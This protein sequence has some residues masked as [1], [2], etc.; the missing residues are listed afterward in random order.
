MK[1][2]LVLVISVFLFP[3]FSQPILAHAG[4]IPFLKINSKYAPANPNYYAAPDLKDN[5]PQD[6]GAEKYLIEQSITLE[7]DT[8]VIPV[9]KDLIDK[10][11]FRWGWE[12]GSTQYD[13]GLKVSHLYHKIG[14]HIASLDVKAPDEAT[15]T[16]Y[17]T[18]QLDV[19]DNPNYQLPTATITVGGQGLK[20]GQPIN[21]TAQLNINSKA[22]I[23]NYYWFVEGQK[24]ENK[25]SINHT[26]ND[27][28]FFQLVFLKYTDSFGFSAY[29]GAWLEGING[30]IK[31]DFPPNAHDQV[32]LS[33]EAISAQASVGAKKT[34]FEPLLLIVAGVVGL[35]L[36]LAARKLTIKK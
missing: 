23:T 18:I 19:V 35:A 12:D 31:L 21:F 26:F 36:V 29:S 9:Q 10:A 22:K 3:L 5:I 27:K 28:D 30:E 15:F 20:T 24:I 17:D 11:V 33:K 25:A 8:S 4:G 1:Q 16:P 34:N 13:Y 32:I 2:L 6:L 7:I 14:T